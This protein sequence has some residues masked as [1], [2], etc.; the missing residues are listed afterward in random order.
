[1]EIAVETTPNRILPGPPWPHHD[2]EGLWSFILDGLARLHGAHRIDAISVTTHG[3]SAVLVAADGSLAA[4]HLDY[5]HTGPDSVAGD[6][7]AIRP[8]FSETGSPRLPMGL[9]VGAQ[10]HWEFRADPGLRDRTRWVMTVPQYWGFRLTGVA[11]TDVTSLGCHTDLWN[12]VARDFSSLL[13][14]LGLSD[15]IAPPRLPADRLG[16]ILPE[17]ARRTG[18]AAETPVTCGIHDSN[19]SLLPH[20]LARRPPFSVVSTGTWVI[21]LSVGGRP[22]TLDP[23]RDTLFNVNALG[24]PVASARFMG[25]R[26]YDLVMAGRTARATADD[27]AAVVAGGVMLLPAVEPRSGPFQGRAARWTVDEARLTDGQREAALSLYLAMMTAECLAVTGADGPIIVEGPFTR[28][29]AYRAMLAAATGRPVTVSASAT[30]TSIGAALLYDM[31]AP[32]ETD[33]PV[34][35]PDP[36]LSAYA[37][38]WR[39]LV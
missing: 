30:G 26:E 6:Y 22:V 5:E 38:R 19:A 12:P 39:Q 37:V 4:P 34:T 18:L 14:R 27:V 8:P 20:L 16:P 15:R 36:A 1:T 9:N 25:G 28:N 32:A 10:L 2:T 33:P 17:V 13:G 24:D 31:T 21:T 35:S 11:S 29:A 3:A 7:D 23:A